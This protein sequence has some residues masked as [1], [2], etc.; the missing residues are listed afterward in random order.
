MD[1]LQKTSIAL[2]IVAMISS[3]VAYGVYE[4]DP[5]PS[6][7]D[8][9][10]TKCYVRQRTADRWEYYHKYTGQLTEL[11]GARKVNYVVK[12]KT[13]KWE[14]RKA[15]RNCLSRDPEDCMVWCL[16]EVPPVEETVVEVYDTMSIKDF[17][18]D[19]IK[20]NYVIE[21]GGYYEWREIVCDRD[22]TSEFY[23]QVQEALQVQGFDVGPNGADGKVSQHTKAALVQFQ[24]KNGYPIG[25]F[26]FETLEGLGI[27]Y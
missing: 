25:A 1:V 10:Y 4:E 5:K 8:K 14:K 18:M 7:P 17:V 26:D 9:C 6:D 19:S 22:I 20:I 27:D 23:T 16:I 2:F 3:C 11:S 13:T 15:D 21:E 12:D 24:K